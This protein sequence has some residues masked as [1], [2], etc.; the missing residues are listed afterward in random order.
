MIYNFNLQ[1]FAA[2]TNTTASSTVTPEMR[3]YYDKN[4]IRTAGPALVHDQFA[5]KRNVPRNGGTSVQFRAFA[6]LPKATTPITEGVTPDGQSLTV[7]AVTS[8]LEQYG[9]YVTVS[10]R[11]DVEAIDPILV[12]TTSLI[13]RQ[14]GVTL[15]TVTR[16]IINNGTSVAYAPKVSGGTVTPVTARADLDNTAVLTVDVVRK[17]VAMLRASNAPAFE[18][19]YYV[20]II[21]PYAA[22]DLMKDEEWVDAYKYGNA[23]NLHHGEIGRIAGVRFVQSSEA[24]IFTGAVFSTLV[25]GKD[26]YGTTE[27]EGGGSEVIVKPMG[28]GE[29]PL[30]QRGTVGWKAT[31]TAAIL[32]PSYIIRIESKSA[33]FASATPN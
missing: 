7:T 8:D 2:N 12:E 24:K 4:L 13:G 10:D 19:G 15:D 6:A 26:A 3:A 30:N 23:E 28:A 33:D 27:I 16:D 9:A 1:L 18:D 11:F 31:K 22:N 14:M 5:Q 29:D 21:H 20:G 17:V 25:F 32:V